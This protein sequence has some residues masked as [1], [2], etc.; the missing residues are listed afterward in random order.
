MCLMWG[1]TPLPDA[2]CHDLPRLRQF[3][4]GWGRARGFLGTGDRVVVV[5]GSGLVPDAHNRV[6]VHEIA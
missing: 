3:I 6:E 2:P 4:N 5:T 1:I